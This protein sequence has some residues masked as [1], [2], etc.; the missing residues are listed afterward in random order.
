[1]TGDATDA[2]GELV[3]GASLP[4]SA[5]DVVQLTSAAAVA[6]ATVK[7]QGPHATEPRPRTGP[8]PGPVA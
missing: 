3:A 1:M 6:A 8:A 7:P 5:A 2:E 4:W